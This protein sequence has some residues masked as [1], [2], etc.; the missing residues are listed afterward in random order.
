ML[1]AAEKNNKNRKKHAKKTGQK[2]IWYTD[3]ANKTKA[4]SS[5]GKSPGLVIFSTLKSGS[6]L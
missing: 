1:Y 3:C 6:L 4:L 5:V 2:E